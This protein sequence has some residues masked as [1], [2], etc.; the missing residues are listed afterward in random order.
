MRAL[1][2]QD[3]SDAWAVLGVLVSKSTRRQAANGG[4][5]VIWTLSDLSRKDH[6]VS[7]FLF[8]EALGSHWTTC[9]GT[10]M[11]VLSAKV[12]PPKGGAG[13]GKDDHRLAL[14][15]DAPWQVYIVSAFNAAVV[16]RTNK[17]G[18]FVI[19]TSSFIWR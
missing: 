19:K 8:R 5:Y 14:S 11:A 9:E 15:V 16:R 4:S 2:S 18:V 10:L 7:V 3:P 17:Q 12:L 1:E 13:G 6:D